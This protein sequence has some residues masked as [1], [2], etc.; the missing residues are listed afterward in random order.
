M[1]SCYQL[2]K[3]AENI[4]LFEA[5]CA[6]IEESEL[7]PKESEILRRGLA[8]YGYLLARERGL[9][10]AQFVERYAKEVMSNE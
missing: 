4:A 7:R 2:Y 6:V 8:A 10:L 1:R 9:T 3:S 5:I